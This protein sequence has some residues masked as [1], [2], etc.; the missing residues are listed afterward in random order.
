MR[1]GG[2]SNRSRLSTNN[3]VEKTV[4]PQLEGP[5]TIM[6]EGVLNRNGLRLSMV[7]SNMDEK[8]SFAI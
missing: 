2:I 8:N 6:L 5:T 7:C 4:L 1:L 3:L